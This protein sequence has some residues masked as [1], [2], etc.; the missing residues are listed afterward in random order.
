ML[1]TGTAQLIA[2]SMVA[3]LERFISARHFTAVG[4]LMF[5][6]GLTMGSFETPRSD[7]VEMFWPQAVRGVAVFCLLPPIWLALGRLPIERV[8]DASALFNL[9]R[10]LGGRHRIGL[11]RHG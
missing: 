5:A 2:A 3:W 4:F 6:A 11:D 10:N 1:V 9:M 8:P 7:Y